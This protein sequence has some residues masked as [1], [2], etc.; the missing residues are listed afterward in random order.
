MKL[1]TPPWRKRRSFE[2]KRAWCE[3]GAR[4]A[5]LRSGRAGTTGGSLASQGKTTAPSGACRSDVL[6]LSGSGRCG[7]G[8]HVSSAVR[9]WSVSAPRL[10]SRVL[11]G[12]G[13]GRCPSINTTSIHGMFRNAGPSGPAK[14]RGQRVCCGELR[15]RRIGGL[16][17]TCGAGV[18]AENAL[19][20]VRNVA[21]GS[22]SSGCT[23]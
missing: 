20:G 9:G 10:R 7:R 15:Q 3:P 18:V 21:E 8:R 12:F 16:E 17:P 5:A 4:G 22:R 6:G 11:N 2:S 13:R 1:V 23:R 14:R 19:S